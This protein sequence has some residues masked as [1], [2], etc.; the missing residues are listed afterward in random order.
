MA[1]VPDGETWED[2]YQIEPGDY[3]TGG[4][5]GVAN[6]QARA[7]ASRT[8]WLRGVKTAR[9]AGTDNYAGAAGRTT[10]EHN[11][12]HAAYTVVIL[13]WGDTAGDLGDVWIQ[14]GT[15][16][17]HVYNSGGH[18]GMFEWALFAADADVVDMEE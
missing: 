8:S 3:A 9:A 10:I 2:V 12:G 1:N 17:F 11:L 13:P 6:R 7:L 18:K 4:E 15:H 5:D 14:R 16:Q